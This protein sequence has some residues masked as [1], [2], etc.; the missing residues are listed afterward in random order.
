[1]AERPILPRDDRGRFFTR[2]C[3]DPNCDGE[4]RHEGDG[5][6]RCDGLVGLGVAPLEP[7]SYWHRDGDV[8]EAPHD[9]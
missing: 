9:G 8:P 4:L 6:W 7:C 5:Y 1:M 3:V 2:R